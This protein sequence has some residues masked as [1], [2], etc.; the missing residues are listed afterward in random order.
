MLQHVRTGGHLFLRLIENLGGSER[1]AAGGWT[2]ARDE[3][4]SVGQF[5]GGMKNAI[6]TELARKQ[7]LTRKR[8]VNFDFLKSAAGD[9]DVAVVEQRRG[10]HV[11][12]RGHRARL[13]ERVLVRIVELGRIRG[14]AGD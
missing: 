7:K 11:A 14:S 4:F 6:S 5:G 10:M 12:A 8:T 3:H 13:H 1:L 2:A 9:Q